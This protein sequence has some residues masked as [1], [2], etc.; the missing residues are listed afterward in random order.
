M[1]PDPPGSPGLGCGVAP[2]LCQGGQPALPG[3][4]LSQRWRNLFSGNGAE[5]ELTRLEEDSCSAGNSSSRTEREI[6]L[7]VLR[8]DH[9]H[10][11]LPRLLQSARPKEDVLR[12]CQFAAAGDLLAWE[13]MEWEEQG[14]HL[15]H[16]SLEPGEVC[17]HKNRFNIP[18]VLKLNWFDANKT[19]HILNGTISEMRDSTKAKMSRECDF[20]WTPYVLD[21]SK[22]EFRSSNTGKPVG[23]L[24]WFWNAPGNGKFLGV[25][26]DE[27]LLLDFSSTAR[28]CAA[29]NLQKR[30]VFTLW[31]VCDQSLLGRKL[32]KFSINFKSN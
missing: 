28:L 17:D 27:N 21:E 10:Q 26:R 16:I 11:H 30:R 20:I 25:E 18:L 31:G 2:R 22:Q 5:S 12:P 29:C 23:N 6:S 3:E 1:A 9:Q 32:L 13:D 24:P 4:C 19:C 15:Q 14:E 7:S 8:S